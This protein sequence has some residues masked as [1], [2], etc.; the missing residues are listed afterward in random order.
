MIKTNVHN[1]IYKCHNAERSVR[2]FYFP[3][4][5]ERKIYINVFLNDVTLWRRI[6]QGIKYI[7]GFK[8][9][10]GQFSGAVIT[11]ENAKELREYLTEFIQDDQKE[12]LNG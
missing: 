7:F 12:V 4:E 10:H 3:D 2:F 1:Q 11:P 8:S 6:T 5:N 9:H